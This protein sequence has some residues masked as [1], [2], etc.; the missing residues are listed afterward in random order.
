MKRILSVLV[1]SLLPIAFSSAQAVV[2]VAAYG[3]ILK[4]QTE[5]EEST[6][7]DS[8]PMAG[9]YGQVI[10]LDRFQI[11]DFLYYAW[12]VNDSTVLGNHFIADFYPIGFGIGNFV[13]G[14]GHEYIRLDMDDSTT[15]LIHN[16]SIPYARVG[17]YF[18]TPGP[19]RVSWLPWT[20]VGY[21]S[22]TGDV[23][24]QIDPPGP[25]PAFEQEIEI[26]ETGYLWMNGINLTVGVHRFLDAQLKYGLYYDFEAKELTNHV[27]GMLTAFVSRHVGVSYRGKYTESTDENY[28]LY[29]MLGV[30]YTW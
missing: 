21:Q 1:I 26:D 25:T 9:L 2:N 5:L 22:I 29:N 16:I 8:G 27:T 18:T 11:N 4:N 13:I 15:E 14:G 28:N 7:S 3:G 24:V 30:V 17:Q 23:T 6:T 12:S 10:L 20:G 19:I